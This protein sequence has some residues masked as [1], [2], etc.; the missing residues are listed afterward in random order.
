MQHTSTRCYLFGSNFEY[1]GYVANT[2]CCVCGGGYNTTDGV[3]GDTIPSKSPSSTPSTEPTT[4]MSVV[5]DDVPDWS[6]IEGDSFYDCGWYGS[7]VEPDPTAGYFYDDGA[8]RCGLWGNESDAILNLSANEACCSCGGGLLSNQYPTTPS[9]TMSLVPTT[10]PTLSALP[11]HFCVDR[12]GWESNDGVQ[13]KWYEHEIG[14]EYDDYYQDDAAD[15]CDFFGGEEFASSDGFTASEA[16]CI[17]GGG[18]LA[19]PSGTPTAIPTFS[20]RPT[21]EPQ[22]TTSPTKSSTA[23]PATKL[24][25]SNAYSVTAS[26]SILFI[27]FI[28]T[29]FMKS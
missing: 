7:P 26:L 5:C 12:P 8:T 15:R 29:I 3:V 6:I 22:P 20:S 27:P 28:V 25:S 10:V 24:V 16:C 19:G 11:T 14:P 21:L 23:S 4:S 9:P 18:I 17:C 1:E 13:C 2:A